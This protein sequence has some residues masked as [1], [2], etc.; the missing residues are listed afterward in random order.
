MLHDLSPQLE[1]TATCP[2]RWLLVGRLL[3]A[4]NR[5]VL[6]D[7]HLVYDRSRI[8]HAGTTPP[9]A[10][11]LT[12]QTAPDLVL[13]EFTALPGL[14]EGHSHVF[15]AGAELASDKRAAYQQQDPETLCRHAAARLHQ[16]ARLGIIAVRDGGDKDGVGLRLS[17]LTA[18]PAAPPFAARVFSPGPGIFR[19][20]RYGAFFGQPLED[21]PD[22]DACV[23]ARVAA[24]ADHIK[25]VPTGIINF[26]KGAVT[27]A[28]QFSAEE[29]RCFKQAA[30]AHGRHLMAHASGAPGIGH[31]IDGGVDTVEHGFFI[32]DDQLAAM[33]DHGISWV[34][35]FA[36]V[37]VQLDRADVM[38]WN[39]E[40]RDHLAGILENH[41]RSLQRALAMGVNVLVGSDA[42]SCGVAHGSG[43]FHEMEL[44]ENAGMPT[45]DILCQ[46]THGNRLAF[47][48]RQPFGCLEPDFLPRFILTRSK[49]LDTVSELRQELLVVFDG[50]VANS[51]ALSLE[52]L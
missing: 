5:R 9:P 6:E 25:I 19:R 48:N 21:F 10:A 34:P 13:P 8:L 42:G 46:A 31:A 4:K 35:T 51:A 3:D 28:P 22:I 36:P 16:L 27:A 12:E 29:V 41:A 20:G 23:A 43:L 11:I 14:I 26:A 32:T 7:A 38:G 40:V 52:D 37:Q 2:V 17:Q 24:G 45:L 39:T 30:Q 1:I 50:T 47:V 33:R 49:P 15:L 44:L 18:S